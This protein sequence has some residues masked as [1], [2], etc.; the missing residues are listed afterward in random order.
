MRIAFSGTHFS[1]KSSLIEALLKVMPGYESF[2]EPYWILAE[3]GRHF[4]Y[5]PS[6]DE[7]EDQLECS[8]SLIKESSDKA[9]FD[10]SPLDF[11]A[12][13]LAIAEENGEEFNSEQWES[14]I[15]E[16]L[17]TL[18][19]IVYVPI[20][21]PDQILIPASEDKD[22]RKLVDEKLRELLIRDSREIV[23]TNVLE[24]TGTLSERLA[25][26]KHFLEH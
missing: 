25:K 4:S 23:N 20:E 2:E 19:L 11:L 6:V 10:R 26:I 18:D 16:I 5:P 3:L 17:A 15:T 8:I 22:F 14:Q 24:V 13:A 1:G 7:F 12:Y 9:L 21:N